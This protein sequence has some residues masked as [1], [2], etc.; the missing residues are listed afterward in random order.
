VAASW[1]RSPRH[2]ASRRRVR[3]TRASQRL[4]SPRSVLPRRAASPR[5]AGCTGPKRARP[6]LIEQRRARRARR[7]FM[8]ALC[9]PSPECRRRRPRPRRHQLLPPARARPRGWP[10]DWPRGA[11]HQYRRDT[12]RRGR[13]RT[14][15]RRRRAT[16]PRL[17][18]PALHPCR[19]RV[20]CHRARWALRARY[21]P[22]GH[23]QT[24]LSQ[25]RR[26]LRHP[27]KART[28]SP[29]IAGPA[30]P[31]GQ[32]PTPGMRYRVHCS[33]GEGPTRGN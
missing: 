16:H 3:K 7:M 9:R 8:G 29:S 2:S 24:G 27:A 20:V 30:V 31:A 23:R 5:S 12:L 32:A 10:R 19:H 17:R 28:S 13:R 6:G 21:R 4:R 1:R 18:L 11:M 15:C 22:A 33:N 26:Q 14:Q 25:H